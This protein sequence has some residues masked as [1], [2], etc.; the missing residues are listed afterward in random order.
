MSYEKQWLLENR[1]CYVK[2]GHHITLEDVTTI[3]GE[4]HEWY[5][6]NQ[7]T[8]RVH[9]LM[10]MSR[11]ETYPRNV[12]EINRAFIGTFMQVDWIILVTQDYFVTYLGNIFATK[13][14]FKIKSA[15][16]VTEA[17]RYLQMADGIP[18]PQRWYSLDDTIPISQAF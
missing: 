7:S 12:F 10:D 17:Y 9:Y 15:S 16:S 1:V 3:S 6:Q 18:E 11:V 14:G 2:F 13:F 4:H 8:K 5:L